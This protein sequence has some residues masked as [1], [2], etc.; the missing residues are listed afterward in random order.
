MSGP[1]PSRTAPRPT[2]GCRCSAARPGSGTATRKQYYMHNFLA[3]QPD[4]NF[5]NRRSAGR[6]AGDRALLAGAR[7]RRLPARHGQLLF[8]RPQLRDNPPMPREHGWHDIPDTNPYG[9]QDHLYDKTQP[10]NLGF[11]KRFP[12]AARQLC[13]A[14]LG[15]RG[16][17]R[18]TGRCD[19]RRLHAGGDKLHMCYTFDLLGPQFSAAHVRSCVEAFEAAVVDGWVC[20]AFSNHDVVRHVSRWA[21]ARRRCRRGGEILDRAARRAARLD[22]PLPGRGARAGRGRHSPSRI[23]AIPTASASG[24]ASRAGTAAAR[25]WSGSAAA[26]HAGFSTGKPWLPVPAAHRRS[27]V[28]RQEADPD[29]VL[30]RYRQALAFRRAHPAL[31][32]GTIRFLAG[33][34]PVL[35]LI[36]EAAAETLLCVFNFVG[37]GDAMGPA[38]RARPGCAA[39]FPG[40]GRLHRRHRR[41]AGL[42]LLLRPSQPH[43]HPRLSPAREAPL[44]AAFELTPRHQLPVAKPPRRRPNCV[45][46]RAPVII[47]VAEAGSAAGQRFGS[48]SDA[49]IPPGDDAGQRPLRRGRRLCRAGACRG[50][51]QPRQLG[52]SGIARSAQD[53]DRL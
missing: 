11:L 49:E 22:L 53:L 16:R 50:R 44:K 17:R 52:R 34:E 46:L 9:Y 41:A 19:R 31:Q 7:R 42:W 3:S 6:A 1:T 28:D 14:R 38:G 45:A 43:R 36:R 8:P 48:A 47:I 25:R 27:R 29:S 20:W 18:G 21:T 35:A 51:L 40:R 24:R 39:G 10:E 5:H 2:T 26:E 13:G 12:R 33:D 32:A 4:L 23:C 37:R 15:R 30:A